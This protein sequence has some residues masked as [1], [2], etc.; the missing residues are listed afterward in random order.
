VGDFDA[1]GTPDI[2][3]ALRGINRV[4][5]V[6]KSTGGR[7]FA[8]GT[9][10]QPLQSETDRVVAADVD[11]DGKLDLV[12]SGRSAG[13]TFSRNNGSGAFSN[14]TGAAAAGPLAGLAVADFNR[15]GHPD[16]ALARE[17]SP[18][19]IALYRN[20]GSGGWASRRSASGRRAAHGAASRIEPRRRPGPVTAPTA[21]TGRAARRRR[22]ASDREGCPS[23]SA[24]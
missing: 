9:S 21:R 13:F 16:V 1:N 22:G 23:R 10:Y 8:L 11:R 19:E 14:A 15:D 18:G 24:D 6:L 5:P 20:D 2:A 17:G 4:Q 12:S 7:T 3:V